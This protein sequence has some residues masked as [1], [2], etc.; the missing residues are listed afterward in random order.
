MPDATG[1][2]RKSISA[3]VARRIGQQAKGLVF[4]AL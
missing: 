3:G 4:M 2:Q 1:I